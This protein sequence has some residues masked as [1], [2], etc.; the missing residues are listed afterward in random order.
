MTPQLPDVW[1]GN[2]GRVAR[3]ALGGGLAESQ[4]RAVGWSAASRQ[5]AA[6]FLVVDD[7]EDGRNTGVPEW[8]WRI[9]VLI[10]AFS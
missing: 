8:R 6:I 9:D 5:E 10:E 3:G 2:W 4:G 7:M 1:L